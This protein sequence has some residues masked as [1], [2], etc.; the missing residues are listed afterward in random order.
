MLL[1]NCRPFDEVCIFYPNCLNYMI[2]RLLDYMVCQFLLFLIEIHNSY[3]YSRISYKKLWVQIEFRVSDKISLK[4][5]SWK[6]I[7]RF[8]RKGKLS[9]WFFKPYEIIEKNQTCYV[10]IDIIIRA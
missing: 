1:D 5:S 10:Q 3:P 4:I 6:K 8:G 9:S 2:L 7:L